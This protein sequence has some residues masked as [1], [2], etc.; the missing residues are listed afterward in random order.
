MCFAYEPYSFLQGPTLTALTLTPSRTHTPS[1][2]SHSFKDPILTPSRT[3]TPSPYSHSFKDPILTPSRTH[4][5]S[6]YSHSFKDP[7]SQPL[8]SLLQGPTLPALTLTPSR[9]HNASPYSHSFKLRV[10]I[11][12]YLYIYA[13]V[14]IFKVMG[15]YI[16]L[17]NRPD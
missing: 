12:I 14:V 16:K 4:T 3:H 6:P 5:P 7:H 1:P 13:T 9:T 15:C 11:Y 2:Y 10:I 17:I 8:L